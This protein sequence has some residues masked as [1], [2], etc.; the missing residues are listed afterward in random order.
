V[1]ETAGGSPILAQFSAADGGWTSA[2]GASYLPAQRDPYDGLVANSSHAWSTTVSAAAVESLA[3]SIGTLKDLEVT[4][5]NGDGLWGGRVTGIRL[6][7]SA[8]SAT[9]DPTTFQFALGLRSTWWRPIP[10]P[11]AP[12]QVA[13]KASGK[14]MTV[15]WQPPSSASGAAPV[16]GYLVKL[17]PS[18][19]HRRVAASARTVTIGKLTSGTRYVVRVRARS[20]AGNGPAATVS[21]TP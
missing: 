14:T 19:K 2:G 6:V 15:T 9:L 8:G 21:V 11:A 16:T 17:S 10:T 1:L 3:P 5:R 4:G 20:A 18:G 7:G 12:R 13:V